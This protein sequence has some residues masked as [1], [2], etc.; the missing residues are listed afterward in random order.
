MIQPAQSDSG[1]QCIGCHSSTP[2]GNY[3]G[4]SQTREAGNGDPAF[5]GLR[6]VDRKATEPPWLSAAAKNLLLHLRYNTREDVNG[7]TMLFVE[8]LQSDWHQDGR[9]YGYG[10]TED[11]VPPAP[12]A[13][14]EEWALLAVK[15][16]VRMAV[17]QGVDRVAWTTGAQQVSRYGMEG[18]RAAGMT[19]FYDRILPAASC[20]T[21]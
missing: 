13:R 21:V 8:E 3:V 4:Y 5:I 20:R 16:M 14:S 19:A 10:T 18:E 2:D 7:R 11:T 15:R 6:S 9:K 17:T 12:F 1:V